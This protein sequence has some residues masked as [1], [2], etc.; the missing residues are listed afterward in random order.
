MAGFF[1]DVWRDLD[2]LARMG[3]KPKDIA[4]EPRAWVVA[5]YRVGRALLG[6]P[7][8]VR[9]PLFVL[10]RPVEAAL[11]ALTGVVLPVQADIGGGLCLANGPIQVSPDTHIGRDCDLAEGCAIGM[12]ARQDEGGSPWL[13]DRVSVG[14][15]AKLYGPVRVGNDAAVAANARVSTDVP[16]RGVVGGP[17]AQATHVV[18]GRKRPP[19]DEQLRDFIR[20]ILPRPAQ[21]LL[22]P[23]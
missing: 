16:D 18:A 11:R 1:D 21:L 14:P 9:V 22:R 20:S 5:T 17:V 6:L 15:G 13:G 12:G 19:L 7:A 23:G 8:P 4:T 10:H 2:R 3:A